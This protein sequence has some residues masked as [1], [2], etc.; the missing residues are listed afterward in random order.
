MFNLPSASWL[1]FF[2]L[3]FLGLVCLCRGPDVLLLNTGLGNAEDQE[4]IK[5][6]LHV[7]I[8]GTAGDSGRLLP[9]VCNSEAQTSFLTF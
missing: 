1:C 4:K 6:L 9:F 7:E 5:E 2:M 8:S 3:M